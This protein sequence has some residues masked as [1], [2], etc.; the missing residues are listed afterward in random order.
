VVAVPRGALDYSCFLL[1]TIRR[2]SEPEDLS[3]PLVLYSDGSLYQS[4]EGGFAVVCLDL[5]DLRVANSELRTLTLEGGAVV[6]AKC[7]GIGYL[8]VGSEPL[9]IGQLELLAAMWTAERCPATPIDLF[10][11]ATYAT[12]TLEKI[13]AGLSTLRWVRLS[14]SPMW[15]RVV[16][17]VVDRAVKGIPLTLR[18][19]RAHGRDP[20]QAP[21][22]TKGIMDVPMLRRTSSPSDRYF[23]AHRMLWNWGG[24]TQMTRW[25]TGNHG[26]SPSSTQLSSPSRAAWLGV[27]HDGA[28]DDSSRT[29]GWTTG[30]RSGSVGNPRAQFET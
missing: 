20:S 26:W 12:D 30:A 3:S 11:D 7:H 18:K 28:S 25:K 29:Y 16:R 17:A 22:I 4:G 5:D 2:P 8:E 19:C 24:L 13:I 15:S 27:T 23:H 9:E 21:S 14:N 1:A 10:I 6:T